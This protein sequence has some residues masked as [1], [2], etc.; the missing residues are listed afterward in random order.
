M[1]RECH[2]CAWRTRLEL[3]ALLEGILWAIKKYITELI[4]IENHAKHAIKQYIQVEEELAT[5][6]VDQKQRGRIF[7]SG[8]Y[9]DRLRTKL[10][11]VISRL[12]SVAN[13]EGKGRDDLGLEVLVAAEQVLTRVT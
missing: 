7:L 9:Y 8:E 2:Q 5:F 3:A 1:D 6:E 12:N 10:C 4:Q 11:G 13:I